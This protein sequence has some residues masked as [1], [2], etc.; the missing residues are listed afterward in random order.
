M[1]AKY[2][3]GEKYTITFEP[4]AAQS[5]S[6]TRLAQKQ[7]TD[8]AEL[9]MFLQALGLIASPTVEA[10]LKK[11][12]HP[13]RD[14][15]RK[16]ACPQGHDRKQFSAEDRSGRMYCLICKRADGER[17]RELARQRKSAA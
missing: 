4:S 6:V 10:P 3:P 1:Y 8:G 11:P 7:A 16:L 5:V 9:K 17:R 2:F 15:A 12:A 14:A 13:K